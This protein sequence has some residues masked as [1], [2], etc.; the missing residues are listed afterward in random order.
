MLLRLWLSGFAGVHP[1]EAYYWTWAQDLQTGYF[2]HPPM[3]AY[4]IAGGQALIE[5]IFP[6]EMLNAYP[7]FFSIV[8]LKAGAFFLTTFLTPLILG[9]CIEWVQRSPLRITQ[10]MALL[11]TPVIFVGP[12]IVTPDSPLFFAWSICLLCTIR[13]QRR[14]FHNANIGDTTPSL[15]V[16]SIVIGLAL[17][18]AAYS[19]YSA[20]LLVFLI[21]VSGAGLWNSMLIALVTAILMIPYASWTYTF[22][23]ENQAG[24]FFQFQNALGNALKAPRYN[25]VG[26]L[27]LTQLFFWTPMVFIGVFVCLFTDVRRFFQ[28]DKSHRLSG[29]LFLWAIVP[30]IL[31]SLTALKR[32]AEANWPLVGAIPATVM[33]LSRLK[34]RVFGLWLYIAQC[35]VVI[36]SAWLLLTQG[37]EL[38]RIVEPFHA[39]AA[40]RLRQP[41]RL[42]EFD[43]W[44]RIYTLLGDSVRTTDEVILVESFQ[45]L[46]SLAF[47]GSSR[48]VT[49][50]IPNPLAIWK[51]GSRKSQ[52]NHSPKYLSDA[53]EKQ[54]PHWLLTRNS[55]SLPNCTP[56]QNLI[57]SIGEVYTLYAC[58]NLRP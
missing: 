55:P 45:V 4:V 31:F 28:S 53:E 16:L 10:M 27:W 26:D 46:S 32:P 11:I 8:K 15:P 57:K 35:L 29:T 47:A 19:K 52:F 40:A 48:P 18:F 2:D 1:D 41:S 44:Q 34:D 12:Q 14:R 56:H 5:L 3:I 58:N 9:R 37:Q 24:I 54:A 39:K 6:T 38:A 25:F 43:G 33:V 21:V 17:A 7:R 36:S 23:L 22:G 50:S 51:S 20:I 42:R 49:E 30:L 13:I